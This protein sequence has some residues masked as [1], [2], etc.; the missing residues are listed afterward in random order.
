M[1]HAT[2]KDREEFVAMI[3]DALPSIEPLEAAAAARALM[4][5]G[6]TSSRLAVDAC[7]RELT[8][9]EKAKDER[10]DALIAAWGKRY[11]L[12]LVTGGDPRGFTV[13][14]ILPSGRY[15]T[16]GGKEDGWGVPTS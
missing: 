6:A 9:A 10:N 2:K 14:V 13:K 3:V 11:G 5:L 4:K 7:N 15:N 12:K 16:M 8:A 1:G